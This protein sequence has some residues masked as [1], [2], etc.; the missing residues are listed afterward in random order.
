MPDVAT[1]LRLSLE[2]MTVAG[3]PVDRIIDTAEDLC[4]EHISLILDTGPYELG[5]ASFLKTPSLVASTAQ[6]LRSS[7][8]TVHA[9]EGFLLGQEP[10]FAHMERLLEV[11]ARLGSTM[12]VVMVI[13]PDR[14]RAADNL[15]RLCERARPAAIVMSVEFVAT[16]PVATLAD[17]CALVAACGAEN[18]A[19]S[20]D[21]LH[22]VRS[23]GSPA[24]I[25]ATDFRLGAAQLCDGPALLPRDLWEHEGVA[26]RLLPARRVSF[27]LAPWHCGRCRNADGHPCCRTGPGAGG[28]AKRRRCPRADDAL[29]S[30]FISR[31]PLTSGP[32]WTEPLEITPCAP[33]APTRN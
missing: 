14:S 26:G 33:K 18:A 6:R 9:T 25:C 21:I 8:V 10:D 31:Q 15:A 2:H 7:P 5:I 28:F 13:D 17:G 27:G 24:D 1:D 19:V 30:C 20:C 22:I 29:C 4:V 3:M 12:G 23:G 11:T 16:T 32:T